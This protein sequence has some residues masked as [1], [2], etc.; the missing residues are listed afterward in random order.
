MSLEDMQWVYHEKPNIDMC[1]YR[2]SR[3]LVFKRYNEEFTECFVF[4]DMEYRLREEDL[5][6]TFEPE[7]FKNAELAFPAEYFK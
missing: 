4:D 1:Y 5:E 6:R 7:H 2:G 3:W